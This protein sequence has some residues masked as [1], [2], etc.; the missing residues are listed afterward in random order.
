MAGI[1]QSMQEG[2]EKSSKGQEVIAKSSEEMT[3][4]SDQVTTVNNRIQEI[5]GILS[6][7]TEASREVSS[8]VSTIARMSGRNV[9]K[10]ENVIHVL[11]ESEAPITEGIADLAHRGGENA[12]VSIAKSDHMIWMRKLAQMLAGHADLKPDELADHHSCRL[13]KWYDAQTSQQFT[14]LPEWAELGKPHQAVHAAGIEAAR[15][16][17]NGDIQG[18]I[19]AVHEANVASEEVMR[20]LTCIEQKCGLS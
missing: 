13:G 10:I 8:G 17:E 3:R 12:V 11:E 5:T 9:E 4:I 19:D 7:Q 15:L 18:A 2:E 6:Q 14:S 1:V 16:Y 20:L